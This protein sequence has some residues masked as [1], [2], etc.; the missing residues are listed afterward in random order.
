MIKG[1]IGGK[2]ATSLGEEFYRRV[3]IINT[4]FQLLFSWNFS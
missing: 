4:I 1:E 2:G 3:D